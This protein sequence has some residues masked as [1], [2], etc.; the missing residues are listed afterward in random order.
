MR[1]ALSVTLF[2]ENL[3]VLSCAL[4]RGG[5][6]DTFRAML[7]PK[8]IREAPQWVEAALAHR[9]MEASLDA[10]LA[11]DQKVRSL[12]A[13]LDALR[14]EKNRASEQIAARK[15]EGGSIDAI[16][17]RMKEVARGI[18]QIESDLQAAE[19]ESLAFLY[20]L[21]NVPRATVPV[22]RSEAD[23]VVLRS[24]GERP[25]FTF[26]PKA[27]WEIGEALGILDFPRGVKMA[28]ARAVVYRGTGAALERALANFMLDLHVQEHGYLEIFPPLL[29]NRDSMRTT[30]QLPKFEEDLFYMERD[31]LFL[32]PT[33]EVPLT[34]LHRDEILSEADLPLRYVA[35]T[36]CF[37]REAGSYGRDTRG[38]IR[39]HQ[40]HKVELVV[41][42]TP[43]RSDEMLSQI[44]QEAEAVLVRLGL[45]YRVVALCTGDLGFSAA[46]TYDIEV[47]LPSQGCYREISSC[48]HFDAFQARR[49]A[50]RYRTSSGRVQPVH[51]LNGSGLAVGR[52]VVAI[53]ENY[54]Q[55]DGSVVIPEALRP[56]MRGIER[57][58]PE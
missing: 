24:C 31:D 10:W 4:T 1:N 2:R 29:V 8:R 22:G 18:G 6:G 42:C 30:G 46:Q 33:A 50:I 36:P 17:A 15:K 34:N 13:Q 26:T 40:F 58:V 41:F 27:H 9:Q 52:T 20:S 21:P 32:I 54:Q 51:T 43:D 35:H 44:T 28:G 7:D 49:G 57:I 16:F 55:A 48:S 5:T 12:K 11:L 39:Q 37:R 38:L 47:W 19:A 25:V 3:S 53:L 14:S 56:Y 45:P 23:N